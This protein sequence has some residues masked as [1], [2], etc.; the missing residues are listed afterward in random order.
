M[1]C[2]ETLIWTKFNYFKF[3]RILSLFDIHLAY[4]NSLWSKRSYL[5]IIQIMLPF[6][7]RFFF[8]WLSNL[9][10]DLL[11][12][13]LFIYYMNNFYL[14]QFAQ[15]PIFSCIDYYTD[16]TFFFSF[17]MALQSMKFSQI[18]M[19][20][21]PYR[22]LNV[23]VSFVEMNEQ[24]IMMKMNKHKWILRGKYCTF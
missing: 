24:T 18:H 11:N 7:I 15:T 13:R 6:L 5:S 10:F 3:K 19:R 2:L 12:L 20:V 17:E 8:R 23:F 1:W 22:I 9:S 16:E 21:K 4:R 14:L